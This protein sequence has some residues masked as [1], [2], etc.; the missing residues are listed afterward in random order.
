VKPVKYTVRHHYRYVYT[1]P[2]SEVKQRLI[3]IPPDQHCD[4]RLLSFDLNVRGV[5]G[6]LAVDWQTDPFGNR[7]CRVEAERVDHALDFEARFTVCRQP[8]AESRADGFHD[9]LLFTALTA[10]NQR[11]MA[12]AQEIATRASSVQD[13]VELAHDWTA[14]SIA[15]QVG[16]TGTQTP[17]AMALHLG[18][19]VCQDYAH[20]MLGVL[21]ALDIPCRYISG[22]LLG[23]G[24]PHAWVEVLVDDT[25]AAYDPTHHR[26]A[27]LNYIVVATGRDFADV[28]ATSGVFTGSA[29]GRLHWSKQASVLTE[30]GEVAA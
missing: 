18:Q 28:T 5:T 21:R 16:V 25:I 19:G 14:G 11:I 1:S 2:I 23:E 12:A 3:M 30:V 24:A 15:Y 26:R 10:R 17:A 8:A 7:V 6:R 13:R 20:I 4:Q 9:G 27:G 22:H 29:T